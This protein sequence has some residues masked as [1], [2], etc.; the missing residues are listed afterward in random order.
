M[1]L[2]LKESITVEKGAVYQPG[3]LIYG[4]STTSGAN[5]IRRCKGFSSTVT[6][7]VTSIEQVY[8]LGWD[9]EHLLNYV[10]I[11]G[12]VEKRQGF[13]STIIDTITPAHGGY[14]ITW[15]DGNL[16]TATG[17][18][19]WKYKGFSGEADR[20]I[21]SGS[22]VYGLAFDGKNL[23]ST[24]SVSGVTKINKHKGCTG[25]ITD[26]FDYPYTMPHGLAWDGEN[27]CISDH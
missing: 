23:Y 6:D 15:G 11:Y 24:C 18:E 16:Y 22:G 9:G 27:I 5:E 17:D 4:T 2:K 1:K 14:D 26:S 8:G 10:H 25:T 13:S 12:W 19:I 3:N 7:L 20:C 21:Y